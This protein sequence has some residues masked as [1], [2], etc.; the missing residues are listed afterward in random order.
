MS[1][2]AE[3]IYDLHKL[4]EQ[5]ILKW[6]F[7]HNFLSSKLTSYMLYVKKYNSYRRDGFKHTEAIYKTSFDH[8]ISARTV[9]RAIKQMTDLNYWDFNANT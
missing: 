3:E 1:I 2:T 8:D 4:E 7:V 9:R 5:G 6:L